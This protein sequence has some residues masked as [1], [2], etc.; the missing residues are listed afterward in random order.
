MEH[1][2]EPIKLCYSVTISQSIDSLQYRFVEKLLSR[3]RYAILT[4]LGAEHITT[5]PL[6][7]P[8]E[9]FRKLSNAMQCFKTAQQ[10]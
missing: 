10:H 4:Y 2:D 6:C 9:A 5:L 3:T 8:R 7:N 1:I